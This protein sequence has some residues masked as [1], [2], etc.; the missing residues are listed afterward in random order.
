[1]INKWLLGRG[2]WK[3]VLRQGS[4]W[5]QHPLASLWNDCA[6]DGPRG[7]SRKGKSDGVQQSQFPVARCDHG[8]V[9]NI[10]SP[11]SVASQNYIFG[12]KVR[13][14]NSLKR[15]CKRISVLLAPDSGRGVLERSMG[16]TNPSARPI[17]GHHERRHRRAFGWYL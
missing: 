6:A 2:G 9:M 17:A 15:V 12:G 5:S 10:S 8:A 1:M 7:G 14:N 3:R 11:G 13:V 4:M 16:A